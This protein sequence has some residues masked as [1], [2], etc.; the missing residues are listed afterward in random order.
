MSRSVFFILCVLK[1]LCCNAQQ[2]TY[3]SNHPEDGDSYV[4]NEI[5]SLPIGRDG[6]DVIWNFSECEFSGLQESISYGS[7]NDT[8]F[9]RVKHD[10]M[11]FLKNNIDSLFVSGYETPQIRMH[12]SS[13]IIELPFPFALYDSSEKHYRGT[14]VYCDFLDICEEG[15]KLVEVDAKGIIVLSESDTLRNVLRVHSQ[16]ISSLGMH[17]VPDSFIVD[18]IRYKQEIEDC[19]F[20]FARGFRY[21]VFEYRNTTFYDDMVHVSNIRSS[22]C[23][24]PVEQIKLNDPINKE[25]Q[26]Q[27]SISSALENDIFHYDLLYDGNQLKISYNV[28][29]FATINVLVCNKMGMLFFRERKESETGLNYN[30]AFDC[31]QLPRDEYIIYI[32]VNGKVYSEKIKK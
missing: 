3:D 12:Y 27:D 15:V 21:P 25:I 32:N 8:S 17:H 5:M 16:K 7:I 6:E 13:P 11:Y 30:M 23:F 31:S 4:I 22:Y 26:K 14:G 29:A 28:D 24:L 1:V 19:Y 18:T 10:A 2:L 9:V 20:W